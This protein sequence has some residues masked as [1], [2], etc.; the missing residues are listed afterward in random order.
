MSVVPTI[1][2]RPHGMTNSTLVSVR[3]ISPLSPSM[4]RRGTSRC[5]PLLARTRSPIV[6]LPAGSPERSIVP[7]SSLHTPVAAITARARTS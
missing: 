2:C 7:T 5:T 4:Q 6:V 1:Q 3:R